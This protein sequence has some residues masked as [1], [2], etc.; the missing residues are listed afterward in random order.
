MRISLFICLLFFSAQLSAQKIVEVGRSQTDYIIIADVQNTNSWTEVLL[1]V[2]PTKDM[3]ATLHA[4]TGTYPFVLT[5]QK[6]NRYALIKQ[7]GWQGSDNGGFGKRKLNAG[8]S[9]EVKLFFNRLPKAEDIYSM[10]EVNCDHEGCWNFYDIKLKEVAKEEANVTFDKAWVDY[11][12]Y[13]DKGKYGMRIHA[14]FNVKNMKGKLCYLS[15]RFMNDKDEF[16]TTTNTA[17]QNT[18][19]QIAIYRSLRPSYEATVYNDESVFM[20]YDELGLTQGKYNLKYD[21]DLLDE[22]GALLKHFT[23]GNFTYTRN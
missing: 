20:P 18:N 11:D 12:V 22:S 5:D 8:L 17:F 15:S 13:D 14:K 7:M 6:G 19:G 4:P 3:E 9:F 16:L 21:I 23:I 10:T 2:S 1:K